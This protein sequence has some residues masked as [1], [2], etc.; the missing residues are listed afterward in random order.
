[1]EIPGYP[2]EFI[3]IHLYKA[4]EN[5]DDGLEREYW[6]HGVLVRS[7]RPA[8]DIVGG[9]YEREPWS[10]YLGWFWGEADVPGIR[11]LV[12][13][14]D[15]RREKGLQPTNENPIRLVSRI[16]RGLVLSTEHPF[17]AAMT[18][19]IEQFLSPHLDALRK[20]MEQAARDSGMSP[21]TNRRLRE[22]GRV[23]GQFFD[24][25]QDPVTGDQPGMNVASGL[26]IIPSAQEVEPGRAARF[27]VRYRPRPGEIDFAQTAQVSISAGSAQVTPAD[28][29]LLNRGGYSSRS[30]SVTGLELGDLAEIGV[31]VGNN[32]ANCL[33]QC[34]KPDPPQAIDRL[35]FE[36][37]TYRLRDGGKR[38]LIVLAPWELAADETL[39][40]SI[41]GDPAISIV[42]R[43]TNF[44]YD[45]GRHCGV[46]TVEV[47]GRGVGSKA[48]V[49]ASIGDSTAV[50]E[51]FA[52]AE[53]TGGISV[54]LV[55]EAFPQRA[56]WD[57]S[58]LRVSALDR[59]L[60]RYLGPR[61]GWPGQDTVHFRAILAEIVAFHSARR[62]VEAK[63][64]QP[65]LSLPLSSLY[66]E[67]MQL[68]QKCLQRIHS[69]LVREAEIS[70]VAAEVDGIR[71]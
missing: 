68:E 6:R 32:T 39:E 4:N 38:R 67:H 61:P 46:A 36:H 16:R 70:E 43:P 23:L 34:C 5:L 15:N 26:E 18:S 60:A 10:N 54:K 17:V 2:D 52:S 1:M 3:D 25:E 44:E 58:V 12:I 51:V 9:K 11:S 63:P 49:L 42:R 13:E 37:S 19:A 24:E 62:V 31:Q 69:V 50:A 57:G 64:R 35:Q 21:A 30:F 22:L 59:S 55:P 56:V 27:V 7:G 29:I 14:Y 41:S 66:R 65:G 71:A 48:R 47:T 45:E 40:V 53:R 28:L 8:Y 20:E 33:V